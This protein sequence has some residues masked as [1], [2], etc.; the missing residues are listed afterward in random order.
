MTADSL[1]LIIFGVVC[2]AAISH[3]STWRFARH[4]EHCGVK[5]KTWDE[6]VDYAAPPAKKEKS[7]LV[8]LFPRHQSER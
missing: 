8:E 4:L 6:H 1:L 3:L 2:G 7:G 5:L